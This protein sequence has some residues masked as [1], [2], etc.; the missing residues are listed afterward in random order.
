MDGLSPVGKYS[1]LEKRYQDKL[2]DIKVL[3][4]NIR[5][6]VE[7]PYSRL[8]PPKLIMME[9]KAVLKELDVPYHNSF[10]ETDFEISQW[11]I[12]NPGS[13]YG[14]ISNDSDFFFFNLGP[15]YF[16]PLN[17]FKVTEDSVFGIGYTAKTSAENLQIT[18]KGLAALATIIGNDYTR[19]LRCGINA[20]VQNKIATLVRMMKTTYRTFGIQAII[21]AHYGNVSSSVMDTCLD[22]YYYYL[23]VER[24]KTDSNGY[25]HDMCGLYF[26]HPENQDFQALYEEQ[27]Y[28]RLFSV[29]SYVNFNFLSYLVSRN[30]QLVSFCIE[31]R[32]PYDQSLIYHTSAIRQ[33]ISGLMAYPTIPGKSLK[34]TDLVPDGSSYKK[35]IMDPLFTTFGIRECWNGSIPIKKRFETLCMIFE[36]PKSEAATLSENPE[37]MPVQIGDYYQTLVML[38]YTC[39]ELLAIVE[40][41]PLKA[42]HD[43]LDM[44]NLQILWKYT[45]SA[46]STLPKSN[47]Y[48]ATQQSRIDHLFKP[49]KPLLD[50]TPQAVAQFLA[51]K[52][53]VYPERYDILSKMSSLSIKK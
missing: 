15:C 34:Y 24:P 51:L 35:Y 23:P 46:A 32:I 26:R 16:F 44:V 38:A 5:D 29:D 48:A 20:S 52:E 21:K 50:S 13:V 17:D 42:P 14:I 18:E 12:D 43:T 40:N 31:P 37:Y 10:Q 19:H 11:V 25:I 6:G 1:E 3:T 45:S 2:K 28:K 27:F 41:C 33:K 4:E 8:L 36:V 39:V 9:F 22:S 30:Q 49:I 53:S 47:S 7:F